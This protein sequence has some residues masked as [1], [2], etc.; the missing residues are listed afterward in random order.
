MTQLICNQHFQSHLCFSPT[1]KTLRTAFRFLQTPESTSRDMSEESE[2]T[3]Q[4][5]EILSADERP[6]HP[7]YHAPPEPPNYPRSPM[8]PD[9]AE[10]PELEIRRIHCGERI[11]LEWLDMES[12][13]MRPHLFE[14]NLSDGASWRTDFD[15]FRCFKTCIAYE[16]INQDHPGILR[17]IR[18]HEDN[19]FPILEAP[20]GPGL[21]E[22]VERQVHSMYRGTLEVGRVLNPDWE[23]LVIRWGLQYLSALK[24]VHSHGIVYNSYELNAC[25][26]ETLSLRLIGFA[27]SYFDD[28]YMNGP[29][30]HTESDVYE[31]FQRGRPTIK[32]D[33]R[34][35][36]RRFASFWPEYSLLLQT[37]NYALAS[38]KLANILPGAEV[39]G[40]CELEEYET[41][42]QV[43]SD[44]EAALLQRGLV[45]EGDTLKDFDFTPFLLVEDSSDSEE[46]EYEDEEVD[47][48]EDT[49]EAGKTT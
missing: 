11:G 42:D 27:D 9:S 23:P 44:F 49:E 28:G 8:T 39:L 32:G 40:K 36:A 31:E 46:N 21:G 16:K 45:V 1:V 7:Y 25:L 41:A 29:A 13:V 26:D 4:D 19:G 5:E 17:Y 24:F 30:G 33:L 3:H 34:D 22:F 48:T 47:E 6:V 10:W 35:W 20:T 37:T 12:C 43:W 14:D 38:T 2:P 18:R 15:T